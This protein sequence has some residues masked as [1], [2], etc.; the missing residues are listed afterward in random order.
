MDS[1]SV[2]Q[3][4]E[5]VKKTYKLKNV[6]FTTIVDQTFPVRYGFSM[7]GHHMLLF[8]RDGKLAEIGPGPDGVEGA[9]VKAL[10]K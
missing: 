1:R 2:E 9:I 3:L 5:E 8:G 10:G 7:G 4:Q 6:S